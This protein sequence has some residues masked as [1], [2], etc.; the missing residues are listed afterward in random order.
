MLP[1]N[2]SKNVTQYHF[3]IDSWL[4]YS[5]F[6]YYVAVMEYYDIT[7]SSAISNSNIIIILYKQNILSS[8][9]LLFLDKNH[10][11]IPFSHYPTG[12]IKSITFLYFY[13][14]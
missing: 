12:S 8:S 9:T 1:K 7:Y 13:I 6:D 5:Y 11:F 2:I 14:I 10:S 3:A 4:C